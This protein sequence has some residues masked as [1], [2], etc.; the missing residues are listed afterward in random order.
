MTELSHRNPQLQ[1]V[2]EFNAPAMARVGIT[3]GDLTAALAML[4]F[5]QSQIVER[6]LETVEHGDLLPTRPGVYNLLLTK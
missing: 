3:S 2:M 1:L 4:G 5:H 6:E